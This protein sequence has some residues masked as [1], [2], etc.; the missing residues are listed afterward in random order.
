MN[1]STSTVGRMRRST[2]IGRWEAK[3]TLTLYETWYRLQFVL[4]DYDYK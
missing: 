2:D 3:G 1:I 4:I